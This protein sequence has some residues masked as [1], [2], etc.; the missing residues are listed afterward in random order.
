MKS[1]CEKLGSRFC[2]DNGKYPTP[3]RF[4]FNGRDMTPE[5]QQLFQSNYVRTSKYTLLSF[6][7]SKS[8]ILSRGSS[9]A[10]QAFGQCIFFADCHTANHSADQSAQPCHRLGS[11]HSCALHLTASGG[12]ILKITQDM[13]IFKGFAQIMK[14]ITAP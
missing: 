12:Y 7:P 9:I 5:N 10:V 2:S 3:Y 13:K 1:C 6:F 11:I 8:H 14:L 4:D